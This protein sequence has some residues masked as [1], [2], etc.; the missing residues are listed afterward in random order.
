M[1]QPVRVAAAAADAEVIGGVVEDRIDIRRADELLELDQ[2]RV[3]ARRGIDL[4]LAQQHI[5]APLDLIS[6]GDLLI[7]DLLAVLGADPLCL[8]RAPSLA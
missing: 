5:L 2:T 6:L 8:I 4:L 1:E 3:I 7:G